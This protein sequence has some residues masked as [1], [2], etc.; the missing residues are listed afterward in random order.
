MRQI[1]PIRL[2]NG[3]VR[4]CVWGYDAETIDLHLLNTDTYIPMTRDDHGYYTC[5]VSDVENGDRYQYR[6]DGDKERPDMGSRYQPEGVHGPSA[7]IDQHFTWSDA[8]FVPPS[9]RNSVIYELHV[10]TFSEEGTF[11]GI[12]PHLQR[13][14][15]MGVTTLQ[16]MPIAEFPGGRNWG[17]DGVQLFAPN[18]DY[19]TPDDLRY[20]VNEAHRLGLAVMLDVVYNHLGPEGNYL[21]DYAPYFTDR[22][23]GA[24]GDSLNF[25]GEHSDAVRNHFLSNAIYWLD[26][27]HIDGLRLDATHALLDFSAVTFLDELVLRVDE[28]ADAHN[29]R[30]YLI[31][32]NDQSNRRLLLPREANGVGLDAQ[33]LDDLHHAIHTLLTGEHDG[34]YADYGEFDQLV[35]C[36][37]EGY[38]YSGQYT[39]SRKRTHG[40][41]SADIRAD[42]FIVATQTH[43]QV[44]NRMLGERLNQLV[45]F[46]ALRLATG[47]LLL[48]PYVPMLFM[49]QEYADPA[50][51][52]FFTSFGDA[53]L[54]EGV[55]AG[56][57]EEFKDFAWEGD[58]PDPQDPTTFHKSKL[59]HDLRYE[60]QHAQIY[61]L[62]HDL[63]KLRRET[64]AITNPYRQATRI[65]TP[66]PQHAFWMMRA[67][68]T[69]AI[70]AGFNFEAEQAVTLETP[71]GNLRKLYD[72]HPDATAPATI[73][74]MSPITIEPHHFVIYSTI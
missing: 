5:T 15:E 22:Y 16:L 10:G 19:G 70:Y 31:A 30:V 17:Y 13:L 54:I 9:L 42:K 14:R 66:T 21:W 49:G 74:T 72:S 27:F 35:K 41:S 52:L 44:G 36:L 67:D 59:A 69:Q 33:W 6:I 2:D 55:R 3:D 68:A 7:F 48:S 51:F 39:P 4:F 61:Q 25:D 29:R 65:L 32:E 43:D 38:I 62:Y 40:T 20:L 45:D 23:Q 58:P 1:T 34:Y 24:W 26:E 12:V 11:R 56:R 18:H 63:L 73:H 57:K 64:A 28:W 50:P 53:D 47:L 8:G 46:D 37:R 60:G 71:V